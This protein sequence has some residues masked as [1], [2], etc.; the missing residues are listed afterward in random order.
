MPIQHA[1]LALLAERD[2]YGYELR[3]EFER[4]NTFTTKTRKHEEE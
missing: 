3:A 4:A 1:V 2:S